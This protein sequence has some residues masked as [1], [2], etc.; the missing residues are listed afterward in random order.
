[1]FGK[2]T[3]INIRCDFALAEKIN[4]FVKDYR[5]PKG[6]FNS[7]SEAVR[8]FV[9]VGIEVHNFQDMMKDPQKAK[10]FSIKMQ[11][12][13]KNEEMDKWA[14]TLTIQQLE[15][16]STFTKMKLDSRYKVQKLV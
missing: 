15:G 6:I 16:F 13:I 4:A 10:E 9:K 8:E 3:N 1:M 2:S 5:N 11:E 7:A 12:L 14:D